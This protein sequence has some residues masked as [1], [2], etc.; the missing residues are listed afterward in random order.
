MGSMERKYIFNYFFNPTTRLEVTATFNDFG[1]VLRSL[2]IVKIYIFYTYP[3]TPIP[4]RGQRE[5]HHV[6]V[7]ADFSK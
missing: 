6:E 3:K 5:R 2:L 4:D 1:H 7:T